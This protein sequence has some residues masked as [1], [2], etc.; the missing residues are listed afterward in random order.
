V[1]GKGVVEGGL[2]DDDMGKRSG[3]VDE[4]EKSKFFGGDD[5]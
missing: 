3:A 1:D 2:W 5:M 4:G